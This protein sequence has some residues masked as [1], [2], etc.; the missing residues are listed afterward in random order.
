MPIIAATG[1]RIDFSNYYVFL[2]FAANNDKTKAPRLQAGRFCAKMIK[3]MKLSEDLAVDDFLRSRNTPFTLKDFTRAMSQ[4]G[5]SL[6]Q[7]DGEDYLA[8]S[9]YVSWIEDGKFIT[10]AAAFTGRYF[11]FTLTQEEFKNKMFVP[12]SRFMPFVDEMQN[13][14]GWTYFYGGKIVSHKV[15]VFRKETA[16]DLHILYGEE[17]EVQYIAADPA[18]S[19]YDISQT[20]FELPATVK[21][22]GCDLSAFIDEKGL[23]AGDRIVCRVVNWD[24]GEIEIF[25]QARKRDK[26]NA[27]VQIDDADSERAAWGQLFENSLLKIMEK[28]GPCGSIEEQLAFAFYENLDGLC[29]FNCDSV[30]NYLQNSDKISL[31]LFGVETRLWF[32]GQDV[33]A[34]GKWNKGDMQ[35]DPGELG[36]LKFK[37]PEYILDNFLRDFEFKKQKDLTLLLKTMF[38]E[39]FALTPDE[40]RYVLLHI[41]GRHAII[42]RKYNYFADFPVGRIRGVAL[43]LYSRVSSLVYD[44]E[45]S[46]ANFDK[47]PQNELVVLSQLFA[48]IN[49]ILESIDSNPDAAAEDEATL[50][51]SL[52]GMEYNFEDIE[53]ALRSVI[54]SEK[55]NN[56]TIV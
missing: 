23:R 16:L 42:A 11:C 15:G 6:S 33:P 43:D 19:D 41:A 7:R 44:V 4:K 1:S 34:V 20:E 56:F 32:K 22:T 31:E 38:P 5:F 3:A 21:L 13:P 18:M 49:R 27:I 35:K 47:F 14:A 17:Y 50:D 37:I 52:E 48:H 55:F 28:E 51:L 53:G 8:E 45:A 12:G 36:N 24:K 40:K 46:A 29:S 26:S 54:E 39:N 9:P 2:I 25:P 10:R 30:E